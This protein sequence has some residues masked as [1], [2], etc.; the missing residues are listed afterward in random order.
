APLVDRVLEQAGTLTVG[1]LPEVELAR[2]I[3]GLLPMEST[4][5]AQLAER[6]GGNP[7]HAYTV[8]QDWAHAGVLAL[9][10]G[11]FELVGTM[12]EVPPLKDVWHRRVESVL[13]ELPVGTEELLERAATLGLRVNELEWQRV[14]DDPK[15]VYAKSGR[16]LFR[17]DLALLRDQLRDRLLSLRLADDSRDGWVF[18]NEMFREAI[19]KRA[20]RAGRLPSLHRA[21][22]RML[23]HMEASHQYAERI[24]RHLLA[25]ERADVAIPQLLEGIRQRRQR[26]GDA[27]TLPLLAEVDRAL[28]D[29]GVAEHDR[30]WAELSALRADV[31]IDL[32]RRRDAERWARETLRRAREGGFDDLTARALWVAARVLLEEGDPAAADTLLAEAEDRLGTDGDPALRGEVHASRSRCARLRGE[33]GPSRGHA[34]LAAAA[35]TEAGER[36]PIGEAWR[37]LGEDALADGDLDDAQRS[38]DKALARHRNN[39]LRRGMV[40]VRLGQV[41]QARGDLDQALQA[42]TSAVE[43]LRQAGSARAAE[44]W[45]ALARLHLARR[46]WGEARQV[47]GNLVRRLTEKQ[48]AHVLVTAHAILIAAAAGMRDW[49][50]VDRHVAHLT[51]LAD[52][53]RQPDPS[54]LEVFELAQHR[55]ETAG[56]TLRAQRVRRLATLFGDPRRDRT[57]LS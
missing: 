5:A 7:S 1:P 33:N 3:Q 42:L 17:P 22:A 18:A 44:A 41:A 55:A 52:A 21:S 56:E 20:A 57:E 25:G 27:A 36:S 37:V 46:D 4:L 48:A 28:R 24:G 49:P 54:L 14:S 10:A 8:L 51:T 13:Y 2:L 26:S 30:G 19:L 9:R 40:E 38:L 23:L 43:H 29:A 16:V 34:K 31:F 11:G 32:G 12:P 45:T 6:T 53:S 35:L 15:A 47:A 39:P 50:G